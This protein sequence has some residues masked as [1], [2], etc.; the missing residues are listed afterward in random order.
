MEAT[1]ERTTRAEVEMDS[2]AE[3]KRLVKE[4]RG[5][6][7]RGINNEWWTAEFN[8]AYGNIYVYRT[9]FCDFRQVW[10]NKSVKKRGRYIAVEHEDLGELDVYLKLEVHLDEHGN[11]ET[12]L[13]EQ[14]LVATA[15]AGVFAGEEL[16]R[17]HE[18]TVGKGDMNAER[19]A[20]NVNRIHRLWDWKQKLGEM[21]G[22]AVRKTVRW[23]R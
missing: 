13:D 16:Q 15:M 2:G 14:K 20:E 5:E 1:A 10:A 11:Y 12:D 9:T 6:P 18:E 19:T 22:L 3:A 7:E 4:F 21:V 8:F 23:M 17:L